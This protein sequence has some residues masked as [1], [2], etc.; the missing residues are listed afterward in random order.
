[1]HLT[2][3]LLVAAL[4]P[5]SSAST[6]D[7]QTSAG[8]TLA[9]S[10]VQRGPVARVVAHAGL[11]PVALPDPLGD[12]SEDAA[13]DS[14]GPPSFW[15][16][17]SP[18]LATLALVAAPLLAYFGLREL[19]VRTMVFFMMRKAST[20]GP[21]DV[22]PAPAA[23]APRSAVELLEMSTLN[24]IL[25]NGRAQDRLDKAELT[26]WSKVKTLW[27]SLLAQALGVAVAAAVV[28]WRLP[29]LPIAVLPAVGVLFLLDLLAAFYALTTHLQGLRV[30]EF[31]AALVTALTMAAAV[32]ATMSGVPL[33]LALVPVLAQVTVLTIG[34]RR[35][36]RNVGDGG[37]RK[38]AILRV[39]GSDRNAA[40][41]FGRLMSQWRFV[42][43][44]LTVADP[45]YLRHH[46]S[47][48]SRGNA[49]RSLGTTLTLGAAVLI[50]DSGSSLLP[51]VAPGILPESWAALSYD[52]Q[53][54]RI[55]V[56]AIVVF[57]VLAVVPSMV[58]ISRRF[59]RESGQAVARVERVE[60]ARLSVESDYP[61]AALFCFDDVWKPAVH[62]ML[63][64]ADVVLMDLR[65]FSAERQGCAYEIRALIDEYSVDRVLFLV[66]E[67]T[68]REPLRRLIQEAW[69]TMRPES[70]NHALRSPVL[71][72]YATS[73]RE[74][75]DIPR[76][77]ALLSASLE[78]RLQVSPQGLAL[79]A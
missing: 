47:I 46:F 6:R 30:V 70:P 52:D 53:R 13:M 27:Y 79:W 63:Q 41:T 10:A 22:A 40:F 64:I 25:L 16:L 20:S 65:G 69:A 15:S 67:K 76:I 1:M 29:D 4:L 32:G 72:M 21:P 42:G 77:A 31:L 56:A 12:P 3:F 33:Y 55:K 14:N 36:R 35:I 23:V 8:A 78:G 39:F 2:T 38:V 61:G 66:D 57:A 49:S 37:N 5:A 7:L 68:P 62:R 28:V 74:R 19:V 59:L 50:I 11:Q 34:W 26:A 9:L 58:Y 54:L 60:R 73:D 24:G 44:Y 71:K 17:L 51:F 43:S 75:R 45:A 18:L 48:F